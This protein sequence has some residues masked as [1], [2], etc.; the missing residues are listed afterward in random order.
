MIQL[1]AEEWPDREDNGCS[2]ELF[3]HVPEAVDNP[4][5]GPTVRRIS[6]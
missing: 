3:L 2:G 1:R 5:R 6:W 4:V